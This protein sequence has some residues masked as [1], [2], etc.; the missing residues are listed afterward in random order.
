MF[1]FP[2]DFSRCVVG[3]DGKVRDVKVLR[4]VEEK[5]IRYS[6]G[7]R[8]TGSN[9]DCTKAVE[10]VFNQAFGLELEK[11]LVREKAGSFTTALLTHYFQSP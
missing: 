1:L 11:E 4:E 10:T 2:G 5:K 9:L 3:K 8:G 6:Q 7:N